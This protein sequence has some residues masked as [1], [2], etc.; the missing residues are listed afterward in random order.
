MITT[1]KVLRL[2][3]CTPATPSRPLFVFLPGMDGSGTLLQSQVAGLSPHFDIR[4]LSIPPD[5]RTGWGELTERVATLIR[6]EQQR[7]PGHTT[8]VCGESFGG[9]LALS[10]I[11]RFP[12]LC[13]QLILVNPASSAGR[14]PWISACSSLTQ[15]LP[16]PLYRL[17]TLSLCNLL[18][19]SHRVSRPRRQRLLAAMQAV[20]PQSAAWRLALLRQFRL[21]DL[22]IDR[23]RQP[24]LILASGAD[25]LLPSRREA[26]RLERCLPRATTL[27]LPDS[28]HACLIESQ[29]NLSAILKSQAQWSDRLSLTRAM[30]APVQPAAVLR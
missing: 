23:V 12:D 20:S 26:W 4:S 7:H 6:V 22:A 3:P 28:G 18:I 13:D 17:S 16:A 9:C 10:L 8:T 11:S 14:Q 25:R 1:S 15:L 2:I 27:L 24:V 19:A 21:E 29:V 5:D 30:G